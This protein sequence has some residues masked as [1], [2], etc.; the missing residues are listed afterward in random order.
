VSPRG[1][2]QRWLAGRS[3]M[4]AATEAISNHELSSEYLELYFDGGT[5]HQWQSNGLSLSILI[6]IPT[7]ISISQ[8]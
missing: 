1:L 4:I 6:F 7:T 2:L 5:Q 8:S 3:L